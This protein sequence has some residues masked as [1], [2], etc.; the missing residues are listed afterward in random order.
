MEKRKNFLKI[1]IIVLVGVISGY[2][3]VGLNISSIKNSVS[4]KTHNEGTSIKVLPE[5]VKVK[6]Q[7][8][9]SNT[10]VEKMIVIKGVLRRGDSLYSSLRKKG[11]SPEEIYKLKRALSSVIDMTSLPSGSKYCLIHDAKGGFV[12][13]IYNPNPIDT[14]IVSSSKSGKLKVYR[15]KPTLKIVKVEGKIEDSLYNAI[16]KTKQSPE[17]AVSLA[18]IFAWQIDFNTEPRRGDTFRLLVEKEEQNGFSRPVRILAAQYDGKLTGKHTAIFFKD[19]SGHADYYTPEGKS[20]RKAFLRAPLKYYKY[21]SSPFS[22]RR[23]HPILRIW[24]PHLGIDYAAP[25][26][27]PVIAIA[28]GVVTVVSYSHDCGRYIKIRHLN[29]YESVYAHLYRYARGIRKGVRVHQGQVIAYVGS[30][31]LSTGPHLYFAISKNGRRLNF[32]KMKMPSASSVNPKYISQ[33]KK[34]KDE[35]IS[36]LQGKIA[37]SL[38]RNER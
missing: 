33:F 25:I 6:G 1:S 14:Y 21:I 23:L 17:L 16:L 11:I 24:R 4:V 37:Y 32:L 20:L 30:S 19:A 12:K 36:S 26:G 10:S 7:T 3:I 38:S 9:S 13:F 27:T 29:G 22:Y 2:L 31:G 18:R 35:Y 28:D 8:E 34:V 15:E 5:K